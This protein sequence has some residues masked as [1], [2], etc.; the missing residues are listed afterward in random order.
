MV[1]EKKKSACIRRSFR[2]CP[3]LKTRRR[4]ENSLDYSQIHPLAINGFQLVYA[5]VV[6]V[7]EIAAVGDRMV[8]RRADRAAGPT[9][10]TRSSPAAAVFTGFFAEFDAVL[11]LVFDAGKPGW[12]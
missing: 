6:G 12:Y 2:C 7:E 3:F 10:A 11:H 1:P 8:V 5:T 4:A 9:P